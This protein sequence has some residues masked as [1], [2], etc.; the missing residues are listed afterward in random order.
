M[1]INL[2]LIMIPLASLSSLVSSANL[3]IS[4]AKNAEDSTSIE[5]KYPVSINVPFS[6]AV[7]CDE[8]PTFTIQMQNGDSKSFQKVSGTSSYWYG[9]DKNGSS[10]NYSFDEDGKIIIGSMTDFPTGDIV[11]F[12]RIGEDASLFAFIQNSNEF[13]ED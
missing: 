7:A 1:K 8:S 2:L 9:E 12:R 11:Q 4:N 6:S 3:V 5:R 13:G 10:F